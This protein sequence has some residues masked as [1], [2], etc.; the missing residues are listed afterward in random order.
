M[1]RGKSCEKH[2]YAYINA[3]YQKHCENAEPRHCYACNVKQ[4]MA[5]FRQGQYAGHEVMIIWND[6]RKTHHEVRSV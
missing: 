2:F 6:G 5:Q 1:G 4:A 3:E